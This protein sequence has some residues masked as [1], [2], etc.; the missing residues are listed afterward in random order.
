MA[1]LKP[2]IAPAPARAT[3]RR[4]ESGPVGRSGSGLAFTQH[5]ELGT[6][7]Q[8]N[9]E[10]NM[11]YRI[12]MKKHDSRKALGESL[13]ALMKLRWGGENLTRLGVKVLG[14][15]SAQGTRVLDSANN[16]GVKA[17]DLVADHFEV[18][19]WQLLV[20]GFDAAHPPVL[21]PGQSLEALLSPELVDRIRSLGTEDLRAF[22]N[23]ARAH[24]RMDAARQPASFT[25]TTATETAARKSSRGQSSDR[26]NG[27][28]RPSKAA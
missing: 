5:T 7:P 1:R 15:S 18:E 13:R 25:T 23:T 19:P 17:L 3:A 24:L 10:C 6:A 2:S 8:P 9:S 26:A 4:A 14:S 21:A 11:G 28:G 27:E 22:E 20:P 12:R 16:T